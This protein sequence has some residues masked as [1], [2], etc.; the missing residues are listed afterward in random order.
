M[1]VLSGR[2][3][4][5]LVVGV[6]VAGAF[7]VLFGVTG[8]LFSMGASLVV[9][10]LPWLGLAVGVALIVA[11]GVTLSG[12]GL[13]VDAGPLAASK[14]GPRARG[15]GVR[16]YAAFGIAYGLAS[17]GCTLPLFLALLGTSVA[18]GGP[19]SSVVAFTLYGG[20][21]ATT[22]TVVALIAAVAGLGIVPRIGALRRVVPG[23]GASLLLASG[24][25]VVYYWLSAGRI[26]LT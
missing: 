16:G 22:L 21:M 20:G 12:A 13:G 19:W 10:F 4:R 14:L 11:G 7:T 25:Y 6:L 18:I 26:L 2:V 5:A 23:L 24:A 15:G 3:Q 9:G 8:A 1:L 17:L